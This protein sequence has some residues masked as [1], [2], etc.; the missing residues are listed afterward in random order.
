VQLRPSYPVSTARLLLR[1]LTMRDTGDLLAYRS[2]D[3]VCRWVPFTPMTEQILAERLAGAWA[4]TELDS[5][6]QALTLGV[7]LIEGRSVGVPTGGGRLIGDVVLFWHSREHAG[8][9]LGYVLNPDFGG[10]GYATEA[11]R[12]MLRLGFD[13]LGLHR[14]VARV[15]ARNDASLR[16]A[17]RL[18]MRREAHLVRNEMFKGEWSDEV[19]FAILAEEWHAQ[20]RNA[21]SVG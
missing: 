18:G 5:A 21:P 12:A 9:E 19:D 1:P 17:G 10:M 4:R 20:Q 14:I 2:R 7:E 11:A 3:D 6:G 8:G 13:D 16:T 15:D